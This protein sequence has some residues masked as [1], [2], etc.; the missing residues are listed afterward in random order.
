[1]PE[2]IATWNPARGV[3]ER[4][5]TNILCGHSALYSPT[6]PVSGTMRSGRL[7]PLPQQAR[8]TAGSE[9]SYLP[10]PDAGHQRKRTRTS[11]LLHG[12][13]EDGTLLPTP[14]ANQYECEPETMLERREA[15]KE[16]GINGNGFGLTTAMAVSLLPTPNASDAWVDDANIS[17]EARIRQYWRDGSPH[18]TTGSLAKD[19]RDKLLPT[20]TADDAKSA[21]NTTANRNK[22]PVGIHG[23]ETLTDVVVPPKHAL[24]PT[25][26]Q[27]DALGGHQSR[28]GDR[29][30][31]PL[32]GGIHKV[33]PTPNSRDWKGSPSKAWSGQASLPRATAELNSESSSGDST[34]QPSGDGKLDSDGQLH[35]QLSLDQMG[36]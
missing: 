8:R 20:P 32:L 12:L 3:W 18:S 28:S 19:I 26:S 24:L 2:P 30:D 5:E 23:G 33:L 1:V 9:S 25:P 13:V 35:G 7:Y 36:E 4:A 17:E 16:R 27:A 22:I 11:V 31:E 14:S 6:F 10:T 29:K 21:R 15:Q 34:S